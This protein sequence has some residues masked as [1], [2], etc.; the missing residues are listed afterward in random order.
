MNVKFNEISKESNWLKRHGWVSIT[1]IALSVF[2]LFAIVNWQS[3]AS[4][5]TISTLSYLFLAVLGLCGYLE[6]RYRY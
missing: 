4:T 3:L 1:L 5:S 2:P 6:R